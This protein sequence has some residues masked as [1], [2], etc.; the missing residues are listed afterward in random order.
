MSDNEYEN[1]NSDSESNASD[2]DINDITDAVIDD[3]ED[4]NVADVAAIDATDAVVDDEDV[5]ENDDIENDDIDNN[6]SNSNKNSTLNG[7]NNIQLDYSD[8]ET[9]QINTFDTENIRNFI[10]DSHPECILH[11]ADEIAKMSVVIRNSNGIIIDPLHKTFPFLSKFEKTKVIGVRAKQIDYGATP[12]VNTTN[13]ID[14]YLIANMEFN[15]KKIP[16]IIRR[17]IPNGGF[18]YWKL[19]DL[20]CVV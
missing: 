4:D 14:S 19:I 3:V 17:P 16:F 15:E 8:E 20:E 1:N 5:E 12:L 18:E 2:V 10:L 7:V 6:N 9:E 13:I 11:N